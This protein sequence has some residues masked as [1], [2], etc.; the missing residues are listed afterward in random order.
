MID[1]GKALRKAIR[2]CS[3]S[4]RSSIAATATMPTPGY[5]DSA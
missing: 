3:A 5:A 1:G 2:T 4:T